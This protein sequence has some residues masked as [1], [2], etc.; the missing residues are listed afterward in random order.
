MLSELGG[1]QKVNLQRDVEVLM[2]DFLLPG[3]KPERFFG[4]IIGKV[5]ES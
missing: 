3:I 4:K 5:I 1:G 2:L